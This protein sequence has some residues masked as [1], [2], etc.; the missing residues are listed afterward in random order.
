MSHV[1]ETD[2]PFAAGQRAMRRAAWPEARAC[3]E[4]GI[5][6]RETAEAQEA[7]SWACWWLDDFEAVVQ[8]RQTAFRLYRQIH[9]DLGAARMAIWLASDYCDFAG[10]E[11]VSGGWLRRAESLLEPLPEAP[12]HGWLRLIGADTALSFAADVA[13]AKA[14][15]TAAAAIGR[16]FGEL[17]LI[18]MSLAVQGFALVSEG[19]VRAGVKCLDE[20]ATAATSGELTRMS[21]PIWILCYLIYSCERVRD[22]DRAAQWCQK[23]REIAD[24]LRFLFPRGICRVH[25]AGVLIQRGHWGEAESELSEAE[26]LFSASRKKKLSP[27][28]DAPQRLAAT[29]PPYLRR[30]AVA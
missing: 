22:F 20:A 18:M 26:S 14:A 7:L 5:R 15:A 10:E 12:E 24:R 25:Y 23:M 29:A 16:R 6:R 27:A 8:A 30:H 9:D 1:D 3:F 11:A 28:R 4:E 17:D 2:D 19:D 13:G 21:A